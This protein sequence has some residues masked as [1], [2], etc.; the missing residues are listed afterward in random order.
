M[1]KQWSCASLQAG[2]EAVMGDSDADLAHQEE[3]L[4]KQIEEM[5]RLAL[6]PM[7]ASSTLAPVPE[8]ADELRE[9]LNTVNFPA[10]PAAVQPAEVPPE[11][12]ELLREAARARILRMIAPKKK[13]TDL[14]VPE[15]VREQWHR[16][17]KAKSEMEEL[18][19]EHNGDKDRGSGVVK[20]YVV[21]LVSCITYS[22][23]E[24]KFLSELLLIV[25]KIK[26]FVVKKDQGWYTEPEMKADLGAKK[27][28]E[29]DPALHRRNQYDGQ[30]EYYVTVRETAVHSQTHE[31]TEEQRQSGKA[32]KPLE[33]KPD[34]FADLEKAAAR[35][36]QPSDL[37][38][39]YS[40]DCQKS[41]DGLEEHVLKLEAEHGK[42]TDQ[43]AKGEADGFN[44]TSSSATASELQVR[45]LGFNL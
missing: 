8:Q 22:V 28:C 18:L 35:G 43:M 34:E 12:Q 16:G 6:M 7:L 11:V 1:S 31:I 37:R 9:N 27:I 15:Y 30:W 32:A 41:A 29:A 42:L 21:C 2:Y 4:K 17:T 40:Q 20:T 24:E 26:K 39:N 44:T 13:R 19:L 38:A 25:K 36:S 45:W 23:V 33:F 10:P 14:S 3:M 5:E